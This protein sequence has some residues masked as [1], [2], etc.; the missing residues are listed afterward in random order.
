MSAEI[1]IVNVLNWSLEQ[2][3]CHRT[4][5]RNLRSIINLNEL[6]HTEDIESTCSYDRWMQMTK[7][8]MEL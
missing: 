7:E 8:G 5:F 6:L 2:K 1:R 4:F 3:N